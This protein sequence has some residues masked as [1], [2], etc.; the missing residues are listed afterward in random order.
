[1]TTFHSLIQFFVLGAL[2]LLGCSPQTPRDPAAELRHSLIGTWY[3]K[4]EMDFHYI[5]TF[6]ENGTAEEKMVV[7]GEAEKSQ[8]G[9]QAFKV[10]FDDFSDE[11]GDKH[12]VPVL[13][14]AT[15]GVP[16][17]FTIEENGALLRGI[18]TANSS[19]RYRKQKW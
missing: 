11:Y 4:D 9:P 16:L 6:Y 18:S 3:G 14:I 10:Y 19:E 17:K 15:G 1:M 5:L 12:K 8:L 7:L 2:F 13:E